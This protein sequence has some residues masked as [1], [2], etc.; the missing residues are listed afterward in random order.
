MSATQEVFQILSQDVAVNRC[1]VNGL[2]NSRALAKYLI[3]KY[4]FAHSEEAVV[5]AIRRYEPDL[6]KEEFLLDVL[7]GAMIFSKNHVVCLTTDI[8]SQ[9]KI[10][11]LLQD[12]SL[13]KNLRIAR[14]K[15]YT[16]IIVYDKEL[17][18][19]R[20]HFLDEQVCRVQIKLAEV[21][22]LLER[23]AH[24]TIGLLSKLAAQVALY[25]V[26]I[27]EVIVAL[28]EFLIYVHERDALRTQEALLELV[29]ART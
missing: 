13:N 7:E 8:Q 27:Q 20:L 24:D 6:K 26:A 11:Q 5:S 10:G 18:A 14:A 29:K 12:G 25:N 9:E 15:K 2:L 28:P 23:D 3:K 21:R 1:L 17:D 4:H 19:L 16:K 22:L